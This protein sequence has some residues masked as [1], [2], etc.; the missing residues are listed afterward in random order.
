ME[1]ASR[2]DS[3]VYAILEGN[4]NRLEKK[5]T[6]IQNKC[7]KYGCDFTFE[8]VGEEYKKITTNQGLKYTAK[9]ILVKA[10]G[11]AIVNNWRFVATLDHTPKGNIIRSIGND[12]EIP[13]R[14][15]HC[16]ARCEHC[17]AAR[18]RKH[19]YIVQ[20][21]ETGEFKQ[22]GSSCLKDFTNGLDAETVTRYISY[23]DQ[24]IEGEAPWKGGS[25]EWYLGTEEYL[26]VVAECIS[27]FGYIGSGAAGGNLV[28]TAQ[29]AREYYDVLRGEQVIDTKYTRKLEDEIAEFNIDPESQAAKDLTDKAL[30]WI[31]SQ[32]DDLSNNYIHNLIIICNQEWAAYKSS[33]ML[34]SLFVAYDK[35]LKYQKKHST[36]IEEAK[37]SEYVG[38][39][40]DKITI[41][42]DSWK[43]LSSYD[44]MYGW[45][46]LYKF[47]DTKGNV[48]IW[49][50]SKSWDD[51]A[52]IVKLIG[53]VKDHQIFNNCKQ[54]V[55]TRCKVEIA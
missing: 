13:Q 15:Y 25:Y 36:Q 34:A 20:N 28:S 10:E 53:T 33:N 50:T 45:M 39:I 32:K 55:V 27:K 43:I 1:N 47:I 37:K 38:E 5:L 14:Y 29:R 7:K 8:K 6:T 16:E 2:K 46:F 19:T 3:N 30:V 42:V 4:M 26:H 22:V 40:K 9:F 12:I 41:D 17:H 31:R 49:S 52:K 21:I 54:T 35:E 48:F 18:A 51:N 24:I 23:F 44:G 11:K